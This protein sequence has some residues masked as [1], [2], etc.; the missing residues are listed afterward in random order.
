MP[1]VE[2]VIADRAAEGQIEV[3]VHVDAAGHQVL[4]GA[5]DDIVVFAV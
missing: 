4:T 1:N 5:V 3:G 2:V